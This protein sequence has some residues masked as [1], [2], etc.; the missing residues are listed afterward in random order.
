MIGNRQVK[1]KNGATKINYINFF[2]QRS[3]IDLS[4]KYLIDF[5]SMSF[6]MVELFGFKVTLQQKSLRG[7]KLFILV[8]VKGV[9]RNC[10]LVIRPGKMLIVLISFI[11]PTVPW[12]SQMLQT[13][14]KSL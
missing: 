12:N 7:P 6:N 14:N 3:Y 10:V 13:T 4:N 11:S 5:H 2:H 8:C 9:S 1:I